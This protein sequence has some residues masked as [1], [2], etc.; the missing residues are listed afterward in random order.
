[1]VR[2]HSE[3]EPDHVE[4]FGVVR[5]NVWP[6]SRTWI[7]LRFKVREIQGKNQM[8][9]D[10]GTTTSARFGVIKSIW[11]YQGLHNFLM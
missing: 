10:Y 11:F 6:S 7:V 5:S 4:L 3:P 9:L 2:T 8:E 1:M